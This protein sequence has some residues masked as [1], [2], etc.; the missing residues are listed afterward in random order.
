MTWLS[1]ATLGILLM[2]LVACSSTPDKPSPTALADFKSQLSISK[3]WS[4]QLGPI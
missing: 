1:F 4:V 3:G 2:G